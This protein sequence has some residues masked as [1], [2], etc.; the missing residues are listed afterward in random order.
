VTTKRG[1]KRNGRYYRWDC[2]DFNAVIFG[3]PLPHQLWAWA[4]WGHEL[5]N[6]GVEVSL[7]RAR[8][9]ANETIDAILMQRQVL[10]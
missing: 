6:D 7:Q 3:A 5:S 4:V 8:Q 1:W 9:C 10:T 2:G